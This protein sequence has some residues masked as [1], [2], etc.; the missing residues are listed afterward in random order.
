MF[1]LVGEPEYNGIETMFAYTK[2][3]FRQIISQ[4]KIK[5][6]EFDTE[7]IVK[8]IHKDLTCA[9]IKHFAEHGWKQ[10]YANDENT[11]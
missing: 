8:Q 9:Q 7:A 4:H 3:K 5:N 2:R 10:I 1:N 6:E 11:V